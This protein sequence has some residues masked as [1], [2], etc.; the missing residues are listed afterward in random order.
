[1]GMKIYQFKKTYAIIKKQN[2]ITITK[3]YYMK[4]KEKRKEE[5]KKNKF[6]PESNSGPLTRWAISLPLCHMGTYDKL[7]DKK[8]NLNAFHRF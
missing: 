6:Y 1:M 2:K 8:P 7:C 4:R 3:K 5:K